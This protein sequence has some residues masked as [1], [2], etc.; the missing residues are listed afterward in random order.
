MFSV[1]MFAKEDPDGGKYLNYCS[2]TWIFTNTRGITLI[3]NEGFG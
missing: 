2:S 3:S 1:K